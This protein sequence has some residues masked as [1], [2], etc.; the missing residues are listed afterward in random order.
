MTFNFL[1][2]FPIILIQI[3]ITKFLIYFTFKYNFFLSIP[4]ER[5]SHIE[6]KPR[7]GGI[8]MITSVLLFF[9]FND[10]F[11]QIY[12]F[13]NILFFF[14]IGLFDDLIDLKHIIKLILQFISVYIFLISYFNFISIEY[15]IVGI[16]FVYLVNCI[17]FSDGADGYISL[18]CVLWS[19]SLIFFTYILEISNQYENY[20]LLLIVINLTFLIFN[21]FPSSIFMGD[22]GSYLNG[23]LISSLI[24]FFYKFNFEIFLISLCLL[25]F[26]IV[27]CTLTILIRLLN[28]KNIFSSHKEHIYQLINK[29]NH[30]YL[31]SIFLAYYLFLFLLI[32]FLVYFDTHIV[33][34]T[35]L[36]FLI[37]T[38]IYFLVYYN[39]LNKVNTSLHQ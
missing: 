12:F 16:I 8:A 38:L 17:N 9:W 33:L 34:I 3:I 2:F 27:D 30:N 5:S 13:Y 14:I 1:Y 18:F 11:N 28:K 37:N 29:S 6:I 20:L 32:L 35:S 22:S 25:S 4:N 36:I 19:L 31:L 10:F 39:N 15:F 7:C 21:T 23:A 24:L 26:I